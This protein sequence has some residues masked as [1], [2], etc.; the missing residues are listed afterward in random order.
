MSR[1]ATG[2][3]SSTSTVG[4]V[5]SHQNRTWR[6]LGYRREDKPVYSAVNADFS[7]LLWADAVV[8]VLGEASM[9]LAIT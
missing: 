4:P 5:K 6:P 9:T 2:S 3:W 8:R 1:I 7:G